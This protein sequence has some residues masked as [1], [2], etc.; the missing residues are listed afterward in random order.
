MP[1]EEDSE[2]WSTDNPPDPSHIHYA[3]YIKSQL[4]NNPIEVPDSDNTPSVASTPECLE[5]T[6]CELE[7]DLVNVNGLYERKPLHNTPVMPQSNIKNIAEFPHQSHRTILSDNLTSNS[8]QIEKVKPFSKTPDNQSP[9]IST[10]NET[11]ARTVPVYDS[12]IS[13]HLIDNAFDKENFNK[14]G[15]C[16]IKPKFENSVKLLDRFRKSYGFKLSLNYRVSFINEELT[17]FT[18]ILDT[19]S[20]LTCTGIIQKMLKLP[21]ISVILPEFVLCEIQNLIKEKMFMDPLLLDLVK[22]IES[23]AIFEQDESDCVESKNLV[24]RAEYFIS[25]AQKFSKCHVVSEDCTVRKL[26]NERKIKVAEKTCLEKL[27][28]REQFYQEVPKMN[29][30]AVFIEF[31]G[32][33][34]DLLESVFISEFENFFKDDWEKVVKIKPAKNQKTYWNLNSLLQLYNLHFEAVFSEHF[35]GKGKSLQSTLMSLNDI[36]NSNIEIKEKIK[37]L[38]TVSFALCR[39][40]GKRGELPIS[41]WLKE[42]SIQTASH[43]K[44]FSEKLALLNQDPEE[45]DD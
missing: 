1:P 29:Y 3:L 8:N 42:S 36:L 37:K 44:R 28:R 14:D 38:I 16:I 7:N 5:T 15:I 34:R 22:D 40:V 24:L 9:I 30:M 26:A 31:R 35:Q 20:I 27:T 11:K 33:I 2:L 45:Q 10:K 41:S 32:Q 39:E 12:G 19:C 23:L 21:T 6:F 18:C 4:Q 43:L 13:E 17:R 25:V